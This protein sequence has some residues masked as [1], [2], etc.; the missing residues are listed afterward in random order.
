MLGSL[1]QEWIKLPLSIV[2]DVGPAAQ[3]LGGLLRITNKETYIAVSK[4]A[5]R[6]RL[7]VATVRKHLDKLHERGWI[8]N[9]GRGHTRAGRARRTCTIKV[10]TKTKAA[11]NE[12]AILPWWSCCFISRIGRLPWSAKVVLSV[13]MAR[14]A[15]F[16]AAI[17][18]EGG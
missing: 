12:Y 7:P 9:I 16:K 11:L 4:L 17:E 13:L 14:L 6:A 10:T 3:T 2:R 5:Q 18:R 8:D 1:K 15:A